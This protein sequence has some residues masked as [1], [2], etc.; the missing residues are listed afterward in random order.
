M[1]PLLTVFIF[2][3]FLCLAEGTFWF[4]TD[5]TRRHQRRLKKRLAYQG[6][7]S[8][9]PEG[10]L[11]K[12]QGLSS[13]PLFNTLLKKMP[14]L[15]PLKILL[16]QAN[17]PWPVGVFIL[18]TNLSGMVGLSLG[19]FQYGVL[20]GLAGAGLG[21]V[22]PYK[23]LTFKRKRRVKRFEK[24]LPE[25]LELM[26]RGLKAGHA[27]TGGLQLVAEEMPDPLGGE[28]FK[29]FKEY[30]HGL[31]LNAALLNLCT[32]VD[33]RDLRFF[34]TAV[35][36]QR[37]TGGNLA[38]ILDK[39]AHL[40]RERFKLRNQIQALTAEGRLSGL[41]L[42][43]L[44]PVTAL[45]LFFLNRDYMMILVRHPLGRMMALTALGFQ[46][47]GMIAI[48]KIVSIKV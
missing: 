14:S 25:A 2:L 38:E 3:S 4:F 9:Q 12:T 40:I 22:L 27:F 44:P 5:A 18:I 8:Y 39:I 16:V 46:L 19:F 45:A 11:L 7:S 21:V 13:I 43:L 6:W 35:M 10:S 47:L 37:E 17:V 24:Q 34:T 30:N 29:V 28:F 32:R 20:G 36:I 42:T 48:R 41:I 23:F 26:S 31:E 1:S 33:L 15:E